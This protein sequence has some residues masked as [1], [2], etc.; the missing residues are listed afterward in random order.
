MNRYIIITANKRLKILI[1]VITQI[2][3]SF[4]IYGNELTSN[5]TLKEDTII[6]SIKYD[7]N[8]KIYL[9][10]ILDEEGQRHS[11]YFDEKGRAYE[12]YDWNVSIESI[13]KIQKLILSEF[14]VSDETYCSGTA[15]V[16]II[17]N[18]DDIELRIING[19]TREYNQELQRVL[20]NIKKRIIVLRRNNE[21]T[22]IIPFGV[23]IAK[24]MIEIEK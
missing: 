13:R 14:K 21:K 19:L 7:I 5:N 4:H 23:N 8:D 17:A 16:L 15:V 11:I 12:D 9:K 6:E 2:S 20:D 22:L 1:L 24:E 18:E 3:L 10:T